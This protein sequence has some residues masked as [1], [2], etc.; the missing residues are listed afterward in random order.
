[1]GDAVESVQLSTLKAPIYVH[2]ELTRHCNLKCFYCSIRDNN[3]T[4]VTSLPLEHF[5]KIIDRLVESEVFDVSFFGG[6]PFLNP[7]IYRLAEYAK[8]KGMVVGVIT[9]GSNIRQEDIDKIPR[10]FNSGGFALNGIGNIHDEIVGVKGSFDKT[11]A[12]I[13]Y[14]SQQGFSIAVDSLVCKSNLN[15]LDSFLSW[16]ASNLQ[17]SLVNI[18]LFYSYD[19]LKSDETFDFDTLQEVFNIMDRHN[20]TDL[21]GKVNLGTPIPYCLVPP[22]KNSFRTACSAGWMYAGIDVA[23]NV[24]MCPWG[25]KI[26]GNVLN[27]PLS[28][29]WTKSKELIYYRDSS[30]MDPLCN[31]CKVRNTCGGGCKVTSSDPPYTLPMQWKPYVN[32]NA[33]CSGEETK[34]ITDI[35]NLLKEI[36]QTKFSPNQNMRIRKEAEGFSVYVPMGGAY[37]LNN[38]AIEI[39]Y[40]ICKEPT[41]EA[42]IKTFA[43]RNNIDLTT[44]GNDVKHVLYKLYNMHLFEQENRS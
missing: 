41:I 29:I 7:H 21:N 37:W 11:V 24:R 3:S 35:D 33:F 40:L 14:L 16:V 15:Y 6:E 36:N 20:K 9:N 44:A 25:S 10:L 42:A 1:M 26:L 12:S 17:V 22:D 19:G 18:N 32:P 23:G 2:L 39:Y 43:D 31:D 5:E 27:T 8:K 13:K 34:V 30:W 28:D 4:S 38:S